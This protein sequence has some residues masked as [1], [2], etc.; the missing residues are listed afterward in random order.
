M[1]RLADISKKQVEARRKQSIH[2]EYQAQ[3]PDS[4]I[5]GMMVASYFGHDGHE[6]MKA[7]SAALED[8]NFHAENAKLR[9][10]F[11]VIFGR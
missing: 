3:T 8:A 2:E 11:P 7:L 10:M 1:S 4:Q 5:V 9:K 6:I